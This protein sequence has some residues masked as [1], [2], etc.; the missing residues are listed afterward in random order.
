[1]VEDNT[2]LE[3]ANPMA[4]VEADTAVINRVAADGRGFAGLVLRA[5]RWTE[6]FTG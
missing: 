1:M 2:T 4:V 6:P 5:P 3:E